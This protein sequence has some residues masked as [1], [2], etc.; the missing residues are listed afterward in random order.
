MYCSWGGGGGGGDQLSEENCV[1]KFQWKLHKSA[2]C[3][4]LSSSSKCG[5]LHRHSVSQT[6]WNL[7]AL[8]VWIR[9]YSCS[10][11]WK[12]V[13][14]AGFLFPFSGGNGGPDPVHE[15]LP[16]LHCG[17]L[18]PEVRPPF[19]FRWL[20]WS[21]F[22]F[23]WW[24]C[25]SYNDSNRLWRPISLEQRPADAHFITHTHAHTHTHTHTLSLCCICVC[26]WERERQRER[27]CVCVCHIPV[28]SL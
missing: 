5:C 26:V 22:W 15:S 20:W 11:W 9:V 19:D 18:C 13:S 23:G 21:L 28:L 8:S 1:W 4:H 7:A 14:V 12:A 10:T 24:W 6:G 27:V 25:A 16:G 17:G 2:F 3:F